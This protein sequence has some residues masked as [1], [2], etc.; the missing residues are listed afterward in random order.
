[1]PPLSRSFV[2]IVALLLAVGARGAGQS[3]PTADASQRPT[4]PE[5]MLDYLPK[6]PE[7]RA[8]AAIFDGQGSSVLQL[9]RGMIH[10]S[11]GVGMTGE[12]PP[13]QEF[14]T[15][16]AC[17][18]DAVVLA[19]PTPSAVRINNRGTW[20]YTEH[21]V[22]VR[23]WV[24]P[25]AESATEIEVLTGGGVLHVDGRTTS[26]NSNR[27]QQLEAFTEHLLF[28]KRVPGTRAFSLVRAGVDVPAFAKAAAGKPNRE[29]RD[30]ALRL[31]S[32]A[33]GRRSEK[34]RCLMF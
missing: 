2:A 9:D 21:A 13:Y 12:P 34:I 5:W 17:G 3:P 1:M 32:L 24:S 30:R 22:K 16:L 28:L 4:L 25:A 27:E 29:P 10:F 19:T 31:A 20:L 33:Q 11:C 18:D 7:D 23:R 8:K 14:A 6:T 15:R 26:V